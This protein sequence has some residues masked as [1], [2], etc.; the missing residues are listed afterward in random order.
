MKILGTGLSGLVGSR[1]VE[2]L[3]DSYTFTN[4]SLETGVD[5]TNKDVIDKYIRGSDTPWVF[6]FAAKTDVDGAQKE[7]SLQKGSSTW[8]VNVIATENIVEACRATRKNL[9]YVSTD[10]VFDGTQDT[11][12]EEDTPNPQGW[13]AITKYE[14]EKKVSTLG[15]HGLI[16]RLAF[17][18]RSSFTGKKDFVSSMRDKLASGQEL[19]APTDQLITPTFIDDIAVAIDILVKRNE[20]GIVHVVGSQSLSPY[21]AAQKVAELFD[22]N[23]GLI[24]PT[25]FQTYYQGRAP[26][27]FHAVLKNA[28]ITKFG[29]KMATFDEGLEI[30]TSQI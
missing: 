21:E 15:S 16:I 10:F 18:Y 19:P 24:K 11:Y 27:P 9:L 14:G 6:H 23:S 17:P 5:I 26:R 12:I 3:K 7:R 20:S 28:K 8:I 4:L 22:L 25:T 2:L 29:V 30:I 1:V 13:Y